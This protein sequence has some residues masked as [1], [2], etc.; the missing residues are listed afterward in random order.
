MKF[1]K[2][3]QKLIRRKLSSI[4]QINLVKRVLKSFIGNVRPTFEYRLMIEFQL[5]FTSRLIMTSIMLHPK[6][7]MEEIMIEIL[8]HLNFS[9]YLS[10]KILSLALFSLRLEMISAQPPST[11]TDIILNTKMFFYTWIVLGRILSKEKKWHAIFPEN[12]FVWLEFSKNFM[13]TS[14]S[15]LV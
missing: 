4:Q 11:K 2:S 15:F 7:I 10:I 5:W 12:T 9:N 6:S 14:T 8:H 1:S 13:S 3:I